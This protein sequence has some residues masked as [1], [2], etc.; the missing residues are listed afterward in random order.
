MP[1][2]LGPTSR[3]RRASRS[4]REQVDGRAAWALQLLAAAACNG[5]RRLMS[6]IG[7][8][9]G[10]LWLRLDR[11]HRERLINGRG[12]GARMSPGQWRATFRLSH[13]P[14][15]GSPA[16]QAQ[17]QTSKLTQAADKIRHLSPTGSLESELA[18]KAHSKVNLGRVISQPPHFKAV[19]FQQ[20]LHLQTPRRLRCNLTMR[21]LSGFSLLLFALIGSVSAQFGF[22]EQMFGGNGQQQQQPQNVPSDSSVYR[23]NYERAHCDRYLC[24]DTLGK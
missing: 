9:R 16:A 20:Q 22:F 2:L 12:D 14:G 23:A 5:R 11:N 6:C 24:P 15:T 4:P 3:R 10:F 13:R 7:P 21:V 18:S 17:R 19:P 1:L 8:F